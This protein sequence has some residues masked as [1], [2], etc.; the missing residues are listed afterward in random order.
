M[1]VQYNLA[2]ASLDEAFGTWKKEQLLRRKRYIQQ[3]GLEVAV[4][5]G[6]NVPFWQWWLSKLVTENS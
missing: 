1:N 4:E 2:Q 6:Y 3:C 5:K